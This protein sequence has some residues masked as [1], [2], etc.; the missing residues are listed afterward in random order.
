MRRAPV[1]L[2]AEAGNSPDCR[3]RDGEAVVTCCG[4]A[5]AMSQGLSRVPPPP[6]D[7]QVNTGTVLD[8]PP[9]PRRQRGQRGW[10]HRLPIGQGR[11]GAVVVVRG[12]ESRS[13]GE[14]RQWFREES[15]GCNAER[16]AT[17]SVTPQ[18]T[19]TSSTLSVGPQRRVS[20]MQA[21]L[22]R[23]AAADSGR[24]FEDL[25][26]PRGPGCPNQPTAGTMESPLRGDTHGG[27]GERPGETDQ[28]QCR[29]RAPGRLH[30]I[31][32]FGAGIT[33]R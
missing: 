32:H 33:P 2:I 24:W 17:E 31:A 21:M 14:G 22:H 27:F 13:H 5:T 1:S 15:G 28:Q 25:F 8:L 3:R 30:P 4:V 29:H 19:T 9:C 18:P 23:R 6:S 12:R 20:E 16:C 10:A 11:G 7:Q 26:P